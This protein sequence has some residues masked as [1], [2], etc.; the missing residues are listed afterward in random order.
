MS[1]SAH[2]PANIA[3]IKYM[4]KL[5]KAT[6][7]PLNAS[8]SYT[9][10]HLQSHVSLTPHTGSADKWEPLELAN[11][12]PISLSPTAQTRFLHHLSRLKT[13]F[14]YPGTFIVRS[15]NT[16]P[17]GA[18]L[19]SSAS[20]FA[21]LTK[22]AILALSELTQT[23]QPT[24]SL[25]AALS[26]LGSGSS[27]RSFFSPWSLWENDNVRAIDL[28]YANLLH[29]VILIN[30]SEKHITSSLAH[31]YVTTSPHYADRATRAQQRLTQLI[32]AFT[33]NN[34][35]TAYQLCWDEFQDMHDLFVTS[36]PSF[37]YMTQESGHILTILTKLWQQIGDGPLITMDAGPN[38]HLLYRADQQELAHKIYHDYLRQHHDILSI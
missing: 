28:P 6:N 9:L 24:N 34:W 16:F 14:N 3:L 10:E 18:G 22:C 2:A 31:Q 15:A 35:A 21:A 7:I 13:Y 26:R 29:Q 33:Q 17:H 4:G 38:I 36:F 19:A 23:P 1:W 11:V 20:S 5:D 12:P 30:E 32:T 37:S 25:Q 27:C 8:L